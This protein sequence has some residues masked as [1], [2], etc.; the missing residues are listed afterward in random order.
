ML[1]DTSNTIA[2]NRDENLRLQKNEGGLIDKRAGE[3]GSMSGDSGQI[4]LWKKGNVL[5]I[6][7]FLPSLNE[8]Q[9]GRLKTH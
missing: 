5:K 7:E 2:K 4:L 3:K 9:E 6:P 8:K 1:Q